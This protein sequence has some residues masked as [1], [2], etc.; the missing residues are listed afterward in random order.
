MSKLFIEDTTLTAIGT[1][2]RTKEGSE[3]LIPTTEMA[4]RIANL[5]SGGAT[6]RVYENLKNNMFYISNLLEI[7]SEV[8]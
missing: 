2:I 6:L 3:G 7:I 8:K 1:A 4:E 5:P